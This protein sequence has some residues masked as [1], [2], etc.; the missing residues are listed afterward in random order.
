MLFYLCGVVVILCLSND[1]NVFG[2]LICRLEVTAA[3]TSV[4]NPSLW[5]ALV[6][7]Q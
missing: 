2:L 6:Q 4:K 1:D 3:L 7:L 5:K